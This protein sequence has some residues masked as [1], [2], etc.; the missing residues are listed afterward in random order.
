MCVLKE[1]AGGEQVC[2]GPPP[3]TI[4]PPLGPQRE[5]GRDGI[6]GG[7]GGCRRDGGEG[8]RDRA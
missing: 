8:E 2:Y 5:G 1:G 4:P 7:L 6:V 3:G